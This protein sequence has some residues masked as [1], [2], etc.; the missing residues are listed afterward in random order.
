MLSFFTLQ[1]LNSSVPALS[2]TQRRLFAY[3]HRNSIDLA[4]NQLL[5]E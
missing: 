3:A 1:A 5:I 2:L 4:N